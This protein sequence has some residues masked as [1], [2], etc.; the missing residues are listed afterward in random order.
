MPSLISVRGFTSGD[1]LMSISSLGAS[2]YHEAPPVGRPM[3]PSDDTSANARAGLARWALGGGRVPLDSRLRRRRR[4]G[5]SISGLSVPGRR[6]GGV[7]SH[8]G[9][10]PTA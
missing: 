3:I 9:G 10:R 2:S 1:S 8:G 6:V 7:R 4:D 5:G